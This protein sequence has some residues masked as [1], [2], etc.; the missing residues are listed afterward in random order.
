[1]NTEAPPEEPRGKEIDVLF[2]MVGDEAS[3]GINVVVAHEQM[4]ILESE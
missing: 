1:M 3:S 2:D 4:I